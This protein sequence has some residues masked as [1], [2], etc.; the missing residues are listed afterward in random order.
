MLKVTLLDFLHAELSVAIFVESLKDLGQIVAFLLAHQLRGNERVGGLLE[1]H[2]AVEFTEV[3]KGGH[4]EGLIDLKRGQLG[5]PW[6]SQGLRSAGSLLWVVSQQGADKILAVVRDGLPNAVIKVELTFTHLFHDVLIRLA[7]ER[8]HSREK[9]VRNDTSGPD[10]ALVVVIL[11]EDL[12]GDVVRR[13]ELLVEVAVGVVDKRST[14][15]DDLNLVKLLVL[16]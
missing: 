11:V 9:N 5:D 13:A 2:V 14:E 16:L 8:W 6:V 10:I 7:V 3:V 15:V 4:C 12:W 1:R